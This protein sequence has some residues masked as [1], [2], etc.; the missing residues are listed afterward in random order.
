MVD[1]CKTWESHHEEVMKNMKELVGNE[2][3]VLGVNEL[4]INMDHKRAMS[5]IW[6]MYMY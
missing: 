2:R 5:V 6:F 1:T 3:V 4:E